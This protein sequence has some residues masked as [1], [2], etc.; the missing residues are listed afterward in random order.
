MFDIALRSWKDQVVD[1]V[2]CFIPSFVTPSQI[3]LIA[4]I[5]GL[6]SCTLSAG[7]ASSSLAL[8]FWLLNRFLD[9]L[10]GSLAR[11]RHI[12]TQL[13]GFLDLLSDFLIYSLIPLAVACGQSDAVIIEWT[14]VALLEASFHVNNFVLFYVAAVAAQKQDDELTSVTMKPAL[15]EGLESGFL[16]TLMFVFPARINLLCWIMAVS[17]ALGTAQRVWSLIPILR[18]ID[19]KSKDG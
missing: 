8:T 17:V 12:T 16:F 7:A 9:C 15:I 2:T 10:D 18:K 6:I 11:S 4:F 13:G 19:S 14:A 1:P 3:T 5:S